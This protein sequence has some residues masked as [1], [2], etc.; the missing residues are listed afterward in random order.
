MKCSGMVLAFL[1]AA[2]VVAAEDPARRTLQGYVVAVDA[3][4]VTVSNL[5]LV[6]APAAT[7]PEGAFVMKKP[8]KPGA[9]GSAAAAGTPQ[10]TAA[11]AEAQRPRERKMA[12]AMSAPGSAPLELTE[13]TTASG[14]VRAADFPMGTP[15]T[16]T[17]VDSGGK[18]QLEKIE[19]REVAPP[20]K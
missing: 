7:A 17:W 6:G 11:G 4:K 1:C 2:T 3:T 8:D 13:L 14:A 5:P 20:A 12:M 16:V 19:R 9:D 10:W 15:V 18:K